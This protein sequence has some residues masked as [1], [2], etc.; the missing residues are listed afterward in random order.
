[1]EGKGIIKRLSEIKDWK[2]YKGSFD[3]YDIDNKY[4]ETMMFRALFGS[5]KEVPSKIKV[6]RG[7]IKAGANIRPGDYVT[8]SI[9]YARS[10][11]RGKSGAVVADVLPTDDLI[12]S[13][14]PYDYASPEFV[15]M[16][17]GNV[18]QENQQKPMEAPSL[19]SFWARVNGFTTA[20]GSPLVPP[21]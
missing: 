9:D 19:K 12:I 18:P 6:Y 2:Q 21:E 11:M 3:D 7:V 20:E 13:K 4:T 8:P 1:M 16:P 14:I 17:R 10:Y 5:A 15:Y